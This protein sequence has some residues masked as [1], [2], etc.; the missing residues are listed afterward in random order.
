VLYEK[1]DRVKLRTDERTII[2]KYTIRVAHKKYD[3]LPLSLKDEAKLDD[4][5]DP[6]GLVQKMK[7]RIFF[8]YDICTAFSRSSFQKMMK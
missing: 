4:M 2:L 1:E 7:G 6:K 3:G 8:K 5:C